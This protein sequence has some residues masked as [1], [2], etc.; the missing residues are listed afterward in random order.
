GGPAFIAQTAG[1]PDQ[2]G[3][4]EGHILG[5]YQ[6]KMFRS[7]HVGGNGSRLKGAAQLGRQK[8]ADYVIALLQIGFY[9]IQDILGI[10]LGSGG[11]LISSRQLLIENFPRKRH[12]VDIGLLAEMDGQGNQINTQI[13]GSTCIQI[14]G[15]VRYDTNHVFLLM[16]TAL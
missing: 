9:V 11:E 14:T 4:A 10:Q 7:G 13:S 16:F 6:E 15:A 8:D 2:E 1:D 3:K 12:P 5:I